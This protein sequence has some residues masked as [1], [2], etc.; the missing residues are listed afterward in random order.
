MDYNFDETKVE[1]SIKELRAMTG[2]TQAE[3]SKKYGIPV[4]TIKNWECAPE[5]Q[6]H[7]PCP[8]YVK[9]LLAYAIQIEKLNKE[10]G[11]S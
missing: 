2:M 9:R 3:F 8:S 5:K 10:T 4:T 6:N 7:R 11:A 1:I